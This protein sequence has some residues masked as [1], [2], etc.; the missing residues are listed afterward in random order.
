[1][2]LADVVAGVSV[3]VGVGP[4]DEVL[5]EAT[6]D[7][8]TS[9]FCDWAM[10]PWLV[11][12]VPTKR[13]WYLL[14]TAATKLVTEYLAS[15]VLTSLAISVDFWPEEEERSTRTMVK[16]LG[17]VSTAFHSIVLVWE[18]SHLS[19]SLGA[20]MLR[21]VKVRVSYWPVGLGLLVADSP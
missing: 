14:P 5:L 10:S 15:A 17:S 12:V 18:R 1:M 8:V 19:L 3:P 16:F 4:E 2:G 21:A 7:L 9:K 20:V 11:A 13:I 6:P